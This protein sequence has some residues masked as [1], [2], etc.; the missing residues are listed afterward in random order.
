MDSS[1][2][3]RLSAYY[4]T[5]TSGDGEVDR[6]V[7]SKTMDEVQSGWARGPIPLSALPAGAVISR[8]FGLKQ[9]E[10]VRLIDDLTGSGINQ[11]VQASESPKP[12][13]TDVV[14][15]ALLEM[16]KFNSGSQLLGRAFDMKSAYKQM[17]IHVDS[18]N[19]AYVYNCF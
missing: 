4:S 16:L 10:K 17:G 2:S 18:L 1:S 9:G 5:R 7:Y 6:V 13:T 14:A 19:C 12:H 8:R 15:S 11:T 3:K